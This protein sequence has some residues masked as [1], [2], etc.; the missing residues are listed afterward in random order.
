MIKGKRLFLTGGAGFIGSSLIG[1][2]IEANEVVVFDNLSR[3]SLSG[4]AYAF[5]NRV[6]A[7]AHDEQH[8]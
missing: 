4:R 7:R 6:V 5:P 8:P 1:R 2:L 3:N